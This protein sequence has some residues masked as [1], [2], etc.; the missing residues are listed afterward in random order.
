MGD[1]VIQY[2][3]PGVTLTG[4]VIGSVDVHTATLPI[5]VIGGGGGGGRM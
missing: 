3:F 2:T 4:T 1:Y 5:T